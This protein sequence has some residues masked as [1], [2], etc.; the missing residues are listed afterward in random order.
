MFSS[1]ANHDLRAC[2]GFE[3]KCCRVLRTLNPGRLPWSSAAIGGVFLEKRESEALAQV[4]RW[5]LSQVWPEV[6]MLRGRAFEARAV[7]RFQ[8][9]ERGALLW[10]QPEL[11]AVLNEV[12]ALL[13]IFHRA[14]SFHFVRPRFD[15]QRCLL[16]SVGLQPGAN[17]FIIFRSLNR[18][19]ELAAVDALETE[20]HVVQRAVIMIFAELARQAG[21]AFVNRAAGDGES[22]DAFT[23]AVRSLFGQIELKDGWIH[24]FKLLLIRAGDCYFCIAVACFK[25]ISTTGMDLSR[26]LSISESCVVVNSALNALSSFWCALIIPLI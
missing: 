13:R 7:I 21:A 12:S 19:F 15:F 25:C 18:G 8:P 17:V 22:G 11:G 24:I 1:G 10:I 9:V 6:K 20:K 16:C 26:K 23:R 14:A 5:M 4:L 2:R 3:R